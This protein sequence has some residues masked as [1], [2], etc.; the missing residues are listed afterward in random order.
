MIRNA[1]VQVPGLINAVKESGLV[2]VTFGPAN[3]EDSPEGSDPNNASG[4]ISIQKSY[5]VDGVMVRRV[6]SIEQSK[7]E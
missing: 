7:E 1:Q 5:G 3:D 6:Y 4:R 2:L